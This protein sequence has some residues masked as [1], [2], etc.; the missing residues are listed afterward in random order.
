MSLCFVLSVLSVIVLKLGRH[1]HKCAELKAVAS[2]AY[3]SGVPTPARLRADISILEYPFDHPRLAVSVAAL[4]KARTAGATY[5][6]TPRAPCA[7][8]PSA[9]RGRQAP[10][11]VAQ[12]RVSEIIVAAENKVVKSEIAQAPEASS[13]TFPPAAS[14]APLH[15]PG[16]TPWTPPLSS[17]W[18]MRSIRP[19]RPRP[20]VS[21]AQVKVKET[22]SAA[23]LVKWGTVTHTLE[24]PLRGNKLAWTPFFR[25]TKFNVTTNV[26]FPRSSIFYADKENIFALNIDQIV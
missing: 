20:P 2:S 1:R 5:N 4:P 7:A 26:I 22:R 23:P 11:P 19:L 10:S 15:F 16:S 6:V 13:D 21:V 18:F 14:L 8:P 25:S 3:H 17:D 12:S 9:A 24:L